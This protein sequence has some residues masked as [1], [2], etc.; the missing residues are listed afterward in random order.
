MW[1]HTIQAIQQSYRTSSLLT[2]VD[3]KTQ[4]NYIKWPKLFRRRASYLNHITSLCFLHPLQ[5]NIC[6]GNADSLKKWNSKGYKVLLQR[7]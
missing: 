1:Y 2:L 7:M 6:K 5:K 3:M 4:S